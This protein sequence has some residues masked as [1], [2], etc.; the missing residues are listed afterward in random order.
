[1]NFLP[2]DK[3]YYNDTDFLN[4]E[5]SGNG[6]VSLILIHGFGASLRSWDDIKKSLDHENFTIYTI[7]CKGAGFSS[8]PKFD[9]A[10]KNGKAEYSIEANAD[11]IVS[12]IEKKGIKDFYIAGHSM[13]GGITLFTCLKM[14][15][16]KTEL[17]N[18]IILIDSACYVTK[19]PFFIKPLTVP[20][21]N[22]LNYIIPA[23]IKVAFSLKKL[24]YNKEKI[25]PEIFEK[26]RFFWSRSGFNRAI[27]KTAKQI[28]PENCETLI[29]QY[30]SITC[31][32]LIIWGRDDKALSLQLGE[33]LNKDLPD[34]ELIVIP[35]CSHD[36]I[37]EYPDEIA[38]MI[39]K[40]IKRH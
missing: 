24:I 13:G 11:I 38:G 27:I 15:E 32:A 2:G 29:K 28:I 8:K 10:S 5:V 25:T 20:V 23:N 17:P 37:E 30:P 34:S 6:P 19:L 12:F 36:S 33:R 9:P 16:K 1:M 31:P 7:D 14:L 22:I 35:E 18:G 26:Y 3:F 21:I 40:F 39:T 4:Y